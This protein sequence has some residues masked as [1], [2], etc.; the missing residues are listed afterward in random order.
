MER[1]KWYF[2]ILCGYLYKFTLCL[3]RNYYISKSPHSPKI[4]VSLTSYPK[5]FHVTYYAIRSMMSQT[6]R[7]DMIILYLDADVSMNDIPE[8]L[9]SL[10]KKGLR[11]EI[12][13]EALKPHKKYYHVLQEHPNDIVI[14]IDDDVMYEK[15]TIKNLLQT[16]EKYPHAIAAKRTSL[17]TK[18]EVG[19][20]NPYSQWKREYKEILEPSDELFATGVGAVLYPPHALSECAFAED[21][22]KEF[23][24]NAD[25]IWLKYVE[26]ISKRKVVYAPGKKCHPYVQWVND[27]LSKRNVKKGENDLYITS[28]EKIFDINLADYI[29][30]S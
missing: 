29:E 10:C 13:D 2:T 19:T 5:R 14:T 23:C 18:T 11:I 24:L 8:K 21:K 28:L 4:I 25:D 1:F 30:E 7:P 17:M 6:I 20:I 27:G 9:K 16:H 15:N 3:S 22:I 26:I 12:R